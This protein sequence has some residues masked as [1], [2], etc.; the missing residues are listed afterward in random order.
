MIRLLRRVGQGLLVER[1]PFGVHLI[2]VLAAA[3][4]VLDLDGRLPRV[5]A[6]LQRAELLVLQRVAH[7]CPRRIRRPSATLRVCGARGSLFI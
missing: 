3:A 5:A 6:E 4:E 2:D 1:A 7:A